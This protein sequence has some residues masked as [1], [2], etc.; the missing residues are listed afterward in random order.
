MKKDCPHTEIIQRHEERLYDH[1]KRI[2]TCETIIKNLPIELSHIKDEIGGLRE[3]LKGFIAPVSTVQID[4]KNNAKTTSKLINYLIGVGAFVVITL[5]GV[6]GFFLKG[7]YD[8]INRIF[9]Q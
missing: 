6:I 5:L 2:T 4:A 9:E 3:E 8:I 1:G 7:Y